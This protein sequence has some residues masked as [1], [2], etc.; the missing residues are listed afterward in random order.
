MKWL[1]LRGQVPQDRPAAEIMHDSIEDDDDIYTHMAYRLTRGWG[2]VW[3]WGG[4]R[5]VDYGDHFCVRWVRHIEKADYKYDDPDVIWARGGFSE[6]EPVLKKY[7]KAFKIYYA[8]GRGSR[9][10]PA[11][12]TD[13]DLILCDNS[14][15]LI[16]IK[17][18]FPQKFVDLWIK[19]ACD[20]LI[21]P[22]P[23]KKKYDVCYIANGPQAKIKN[24]E[25]VYETFP[26]NMT[27]L[28]LGMKSKYKPP[29]GVKCKRVLR[30]Q[31]AREI[32][33][34]KVG[35]IPYET[36]DSMPRALSEMLACGLPVVTFETVRY[37][38]EKYRIVDH[39]P[40]SHFWQLVYGLT[41]TY[42]QENVREFY[43]NHLSMA[44]AVEHLGKL[45]E[46]ARAY[47]RTVSDLS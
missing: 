34:C 11:G 31:I 44:T 4:S 21:Y 23:V 35:V 24:I 13:Y 46:D 36:V 20:S 7:P 17:K 41:N 45:V 25:W 1:L 27:M 2:E 18:R 33:K 5:R 12:F 22:K 30:H 3:Y 47:K 9:H 43:E 8:A 32:S 29:R 38:K 16:D 40:R 14:Q 37:W 6:Y 10:I 19:P 39:A 26:D 42:D 15:Q 28:H